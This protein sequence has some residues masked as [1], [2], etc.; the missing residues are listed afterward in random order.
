MLSLLCRQ[1]HKRGKLEPPSR[2]D[3][4]TFDPARVVEEFS[5]CDHP[6]LSSQLGVGFQN[7][8]AITAYESPQVLS[9]NGV[10]ES[11]CIWIHSLC[12]G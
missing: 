4:C 2:G 9:T 3:P 11:I 8:F 1:S 6:N 5:I 7:V 12:E 10:A